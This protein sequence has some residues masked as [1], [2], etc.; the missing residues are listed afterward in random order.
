MRL[1][2]YLIR[3]NRTVWVRSHIWITVTV[4]YTST[5]LLHIAHFLQKCHNSKSVI[6]QERGLKVLKCYYFLWVQRRHDCSPAASFANCVM[7]LYLL[8]VHL[9]TFISIP[10]IQKLPNFELWHSCRKWAI[11]RPAD[12]YLVFRKFR[13]G[14][15]FRLLSTATFNNY[16]HL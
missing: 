1:V 6:F 15:L 14:I 8:K 10:I 2:G 12:H 5:S 3:E 13:S 7:T 16:Q 9:Q 4:L 11:W